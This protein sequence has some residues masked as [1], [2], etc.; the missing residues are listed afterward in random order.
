MPV[1]AANMVATSQPIAAQAGLRMLAMGGNAADAAIATAATIA[2][3]EPGSNGLGADA[4]SLIWHEGK[5]HGLNASGRAPKAMT[6]DRLKGQTTMPRFGWDTVTVPGAVSAWVAVSK[7]FGKL[8][9]AKLL[10]PAIEYA[11]N[12]FP[13][14]PQT[15]ELWRAAPTTYL[16]MPEF[17]QMFFPSGKGPDTG[18]RIIFADHA[19]TLR[20]IAQTNGEAYYRGEIARKIAAHSRETGGLMTE[21]DLASHTADWVEPISVDYR[22]HRV[23]EIPPNGQGLAALLALGILRNREIGSLQVD[24]PDVF[25]LQIEAMKLAFADAHRYIADPKWMTVDVAN[26]L[27]NKYLADRAKLLDPSKAQDPNWGS[28][29]PGGTILLTAAD[30]SGMMV[31]FIQS[32]YEGFGSGIVIPRT[33]IH[34]Q[35]RGSCFDLAPGHPNQ[36]AGGKRPYHTILPAFLTRP[37]D[38]G[39]QEPLMAFGVMGGYMQPQGHLQVISR[40]ID[41][42]QNPQAALDAPRWQ[43]TREKK[44][45]LEPGFSQAIC[46]ELQRRGHEIIR[47]EKQTVLFGGGQIIYRMPNGLYCGASDLRRDGQAV[48]F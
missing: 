9:F 17:A 11:Q 27:D 30:A 29:K 47:A 1:L 22:G 41:F 19:K 12:G 44:L 21:E 40:L 13:V 16:N 35:N 10:E 39:T 6:P 37:R 4:F 20:L 31:S 3:L 38:D 42:H 36:I 7:K 33:G 25:H 24:C 14:A 48:G 46:D 8:P 34:L 26:L 28:P 23:W 5:L 43:V 15:A 45:A 2:V 32:N 18:D